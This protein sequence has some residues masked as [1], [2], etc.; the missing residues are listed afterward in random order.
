MNY[1][2][3]ICISDFLVCGEFLTYIYFSLGCNIWT[4]FS[5]VCNVQS[6][7]L[8]SM[9]VEFRG[10]V[11]SNNACPPAPPPPPQFLKLFLIKYNVYSNYTP[12]FFCLFR[13]K[14]CRFKQRL[15]E[16]V[17]IRPI[18]IT[19]TTKYIFS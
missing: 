11:M 6:H 12:S 16:C 10:F 4:T 8:L 9:Y 7:P 14:M 2:S 13:T 18:A 1:L 19:P 15:R 5:A 3:S 17:L